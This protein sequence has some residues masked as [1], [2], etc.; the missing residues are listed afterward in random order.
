MRAFADRQRAE[1]ISARWLIDLSPGTRMRPAQR[2]GRQ[3]A[4]RTH[5]G[6]IGMAHGRLSLDGCGKSARLLTAPAGYG[7]ARARC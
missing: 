5:G 2:A 1:S 3:E 7:K 4:A 6:R